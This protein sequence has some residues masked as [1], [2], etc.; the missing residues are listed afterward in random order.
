[1]PLTAAFAWVYRFRWWSLLP[2]AGFVILRAGTGA[3]GPFIVASAMLILLYLA[4]QRRRWPE[5][6]SALIVGAAAVLFNFVVADRGEAIRDLFIDKT[7]AVHLAPDREH[8][9]DH[10]DFANLEM[11]EYAVHVVPQLSGGYDYFLN[12]LQ[13]L[14]EPIPR[15]WWKN[16]P[17]GPP[18]QTFTLAD[19]GVPYGF[20]FSIAGVGWMAL[21]YLGVALQAALFAL[22]YGLLYRRL[23]AGNAS[24]FYLL[25]YTV[26][27]GATV[28]TFRDGTLL[29]IVRLLPFYGFPVMA[30]WIAYRATYRQAPVRQRR[31]S[32]ASPLPAERR[33]AL[34]TQY[35]KSAANAG[36]A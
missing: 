12:N 27:L 3:R 1:M 15:I 6:R 33:R 34:A 35:R 23:L 4:D 18:I 17:L 10:P 25:F 9:F 22:I 29:T 36:Q 2:F 5:W 20:T 30:V 31:T 7:Q 28:I 11:L 14:T 13:I 26:M 32:G 19:Y 24:P 16:K 8:F 21:G